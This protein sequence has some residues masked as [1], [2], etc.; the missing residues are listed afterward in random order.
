MYSPNF[1]PMIGGVESIV[2]DLATEFSAMGIETTVLTQ[3]ASQNTEGGVEK[4]DFPFRIVR[5]P[6]VF[7]TFQ[8]IRKHDIFVQHNVSLPAIPIWFLAKMTK[9][10]PLVVCQHGVW[11]GESF[12]IRLRQK[13]ADNL[14]RLNIGCSE[15]VAKHNKRSI[16]IGNAYN[17]NLFFKTKNWSERPLDVVFLGRLVSDK[18]CD[19]LLEALH[20]LKNKNI[21][22]TASIIGNGDEMPK[23]TAYTEG[24]GLKNQVSFLGLKPRAEVNAIL[25]EHKIMVVPSRWAEPFGIV[26]LEGLAAGCLVVCS[27]EGGLPE[28]VGKCGI[29][30]PN[31]NAEALADVLEKVVTDTVFKEKY[32]DNQLVTQHLA[33]HKPR[34]FAEKYAQAL[35]S[36]L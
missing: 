7:E 35:A 6:S 22:L 32:I 9:K 1:H 33:A 13:I 11:Q 24:V 27:T 8:E 34:A 12:K 4:D 28:A 26:A 16:G 29:T 30:F 2:M 23:L 17:P 19:T 20:I 21:T 10:I 18:G 15:F 25:N 3:T 5:R 36:L 31:G 14:A